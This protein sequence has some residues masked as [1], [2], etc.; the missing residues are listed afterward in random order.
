MREFQTSPEVA[1]EVTGNSGDITTMSAA[2]LRQALA[3]GQLTATSLTQAFLDRI[4]AVNPVLGAVIAVSPDALEQAAAS[5]RA[6]DSGRPRPLEGIPV[7]VK[8][9][10]QVAGQPTTAGSSALLGAHPPDAFIVSRLRAA[11]AVILAKANLSEWA[12]FRSSR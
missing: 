1:S 12:N 2:A 4:E 7:L 8:D 5:E 3:R 9:N 6:W 10:V 11:G